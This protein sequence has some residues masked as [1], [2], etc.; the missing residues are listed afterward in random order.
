MDRREVKL[1]EEQRKS[2]IAVYRKM[3]EKVKP[4]QMTVENFNK[5]KYLQWQKKNNISE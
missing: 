3:R 1:T 4:E 5:K 2:L